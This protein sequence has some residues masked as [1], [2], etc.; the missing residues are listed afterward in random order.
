MS[1][2]LAVLFKRA[3][4]DIGEV[5]DKSILRRAASVGVAATIIALALSFGIS[6]ALFQYTYTIEKE[7]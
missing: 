5:A 7:C 4:S 6:L 1:Q 3:L 2:Q